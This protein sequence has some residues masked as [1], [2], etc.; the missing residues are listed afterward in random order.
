MGQQNKHF[1]MQRD[2]GGS[3]LG[4]LDGRGLERKESMPLDLMPT[5][6]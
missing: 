5:E 1:K 3:G 4:Q 2:V 6:R